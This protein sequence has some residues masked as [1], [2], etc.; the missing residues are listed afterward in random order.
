M[1]E[2]LASF[3]SK[4][5]RERRVWIASQI[6]AQMACID[7]ARIIKKASKTNVNIGSCHYAIRLS[8]ER[9][10]SLCL[11]TF[12][13]VFG[14]TGAEQWSKL[15]EDVKQHGNWRRSGGLWCHPSFKMRS[16]Q[17]LTR[18]LLNRVKKD[19]N[20]KKKKREQEKR[21]A[22]ANAVTESAPV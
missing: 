22:A 10:V 6:E 1:T 11:N 12:R 8:D 15:M 20:N 17:Y 13:H 21:D 18:H 14:I 4:P 9:S 2:L 16:V 7:T 19:R 5:K 3:G